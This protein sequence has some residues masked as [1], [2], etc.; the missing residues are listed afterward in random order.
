MKTFKNI[1]QAHQHFNFPG[2]YRVGAIIKE[3][4]VIR[5]YSNSVSKPDFFKNNS[6]QFFYIIKN[7]KILEAF[8]NTKKHQSLIHVFTKDLENDNV[9]FHG[10]YKVKG[11]RQKNKYVLLESN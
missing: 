4:I 2:S 9:I 6:K 7:D 1:K 11:F 10:K 3:N 5:I 8:K